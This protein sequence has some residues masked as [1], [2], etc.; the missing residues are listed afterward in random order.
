MPSYVLHF[1]C[2]F[3]GKLAQRH[4][5]TYSAG[6]Y[7]YTGTAGKDSVAG[8]IV[9]QIG[10]LAGLLGPI[11]GGM[12]FGV[13][14]IVPILVIS[15]IC[16]LIS[17]IM[18]IFIKIPFIK[19]EN[20]LGISQIIK[21]DFRDSTNYIKNEK[22]ILIVETLKMNDQLLGI[23]Q[24]IMALGGLC[25]GILTAIL[26]KK[27]KLTNSQ[28]L[29]ILCSLWVG[30]MAVPLLFHSAPMV[31]YGVI[32][33]ASFLIMGLATMF[34]VQMIASVQNETPPE[35]VGKVIALM[36]SLSMCAQPLGQT[37]YGV[38]FDKLPSNTYLILLAAA[39]LSLLLSLV[40]KR[41]FSKLEH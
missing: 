40:S 39:V 32:T 34:S 5:S 8:A 25:V 9:N 15:I 7:P 24:G 23:S 1:P 26:N 12:L 35:L 28:I 20:N 33:A 18:E 21:N 31:S 38:A 37:M 11:I 13:F 17:A 6:Q 10:S 22:P 14:G 2:T 27:L 19:R 36:I 30:I 29:L 41:I 16:F 3:C 4:L